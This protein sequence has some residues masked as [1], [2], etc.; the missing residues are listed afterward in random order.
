MRSKNKFSKDPKV[1]L[2]SIKDFIE[3]NN[4]LI[5][6]KSNLWKNKKRPQIYGNYF[7]FT[8]DKLILIEYEYRIINYGQND[9][10]QLKCIK[11]A[12]RDGVTEYEILNNHLAELKNY[13]KSHRQNKKV[14]A[15]I[16]KLTEVLSLLPKYKV[17]KATKPISFE[18]CLIE[19]GYKTENASLKN[20]YIVVDVETNGLR[21]VNDDLL[22]ISF[23]DPT[24]GFC[25]N[26][27][28]PL[29]LQ[30][31]VLTGWIHGITEKQLSN[32]PHWSQ[33]EVDSIID[34]FQLNEKIILSY[35]GGKGIFDIKFITNYCKR[36][37]IN[38]FEN[39]RCEN[40]KSYFSHVYGSEGQMT[41]DN[42]CKLLG[43]ELTDKVH[44]SQND[45]ILQWQLFEKLMD[46]NLFFRNNEL[47]RFKEGYIVPVSYLNSN[48]RLMKIAG[49]NVPKL[50]A[51]YTE[52][53]RYTFPKKTLSMIKKFPNNITGISLENIINYKLNVST[54]NNNDFLIKNNSYLESLGFLESRYE[55]IYV[56]PA[57]NGMLKSLD[58]MSDAYISEVNKVTQVITDNL[59]SVFD[60]IKNVIFK[61]EE[62][63]SQE[64][65][66]SDDKK[67]F[68][69][70]DLSSTTKVMEIKTSRFLFFNN[71]NLAR[72]LFY[73]SKGR[74]T[75][76]LWIDIEQHFNDSLCKNII[77][78]VNIIIYK[79]LLTNK[80]E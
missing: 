30:P 12:I 49:I 75:Y 32:V 69:L 74:D 43:I 8:S 68:A 11:V 72:Q 73:Q 25:Y 59:S 48:S 24:T 3:N 5:E 62:I 17:H 35:S 19:T 1:I 52:I 15:E 70:C 29:D 36:H 2:L 31:L 28:F 46:K 64:L 21:T 71:E 63:K 38:G 6:A 77:D 45:C 34:F 39:M 51:Q 14:E 76:L 61:D 37:G 42:L 67:V 4:Y 18:D 55:Y 33:K 10:E 57:E 13:K 47:C 26:R 53:Y 79:V 16:G 20:K 78:S 23:Y 66:I 80:E 50:I 9:V 58:S 44:S 54:Q 60:F 7:K 40:I 65:C 41:K 22:S 56:A 27:F